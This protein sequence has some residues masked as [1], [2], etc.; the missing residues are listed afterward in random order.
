MHR[1]CHELNSIG[2]DAFLVRCPEEQIFEIH[3]PLISTL[4][5]IREYFRC[6]VP[7]R[8]HTKFNTPTTRFSR[9]KFI[10]DLVIYGEQTVGNPL[11][12]SRVIRYLLHHPGY[13]TGRAYYSFNEYHVKWDVVIKDYLFPGMKMHPE[14][15]R[16]S[17][18]FDDIYVQQN[19]GKRTGSC[20]MI[21]KGKGKK[22]IH[23]ADSINLDGMS[24]QEIAKIFNKCNIFYSYDPYTMYSRYA[25]MCGCLSVVVPDEGVGLQEWNA[26]KNSRHAIAY[27]IESLDRA[28]SE[29]STVKDALQNEQTDLEIKLKNLVDVSLRYFRELSNA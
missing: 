9:T 21:R 13:H 12:S 29:M 16:V 18:L 23:P 25:T 26:N 22:F 15:V 5:I 27:G 1:L 10:N 19:F 6:L 24:H 7:L 2:Y 20:Y 14:H 4:K 11:N 17:F 3:N 8:T 28:K